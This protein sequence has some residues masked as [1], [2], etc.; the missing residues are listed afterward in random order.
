MEDPFIFILRRQRGKCCKSKFLMLCSII[1]SR[2]CR[3]CATQ[4]FGET[5]DA[6]RSIFM[7]TGAENTLENLHYEGN[8]FKLPISHE[9]DACH[10]PDCSLKDLVSDFS[11]TLLGQV[12]LEISPEGSRLGLT[13]TPKSEISLVEIYRELL[14]IWITCRTWVLQAYLWLHNLNPQANH[15][16]NTTDCFRK[17]PSF[18]TRK[19]SSVNWWMRPIREA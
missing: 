1:G 15:K 12:I 7:A 19:F 16:Y 11:R 9:I 10:V 4:H 14:T 18:L 5:C 2:G 13:I 17:L 8:G 6:R 3:L